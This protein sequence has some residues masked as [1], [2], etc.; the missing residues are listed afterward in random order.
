MRLRF[1]FLLPARLWLGLFMA[2]PLLIVCVYSALTRGAYGGVA[3]PWTAENYTRFFDPLYGVI[4]LRSLLIAAAATALCLL[5]GFPL[6]LFIARARK[7]RALYLF[8]VILPFWTSFLV[9]T[10][11]WLFLLRDSGLI[12]TILLNLGVI[13]EPVQLLYNTGAVLLGLVY[14]YLPFM[15]LPLY[16]TLE[17]LDPALLEAAADL[18]AKPLTALFRVVGPVV[19]A[20]NP[21]RIHPRVHPL[22]GSVPDPRSSGRRQDRHDRQPG[23]ESVHNRARLAVRLRRLPAA[24]ADRGPAR[25]LFL[26]SRR[27]GGSVKRALGLYAVA[28]YAFLHLPLLILGAFSFNSS[29]FTVWEGFSLNWYR[30]VFADPNLAEAAVNSIEIAVVSTLL[31][32]VVGTACAYGFWKRRDRALSGALYLSLVTPEIVTGVSLLAFFQWTFRH[33]HLRLGLHTVIL[34]HVAFSIAYVV[35][36]VAARLRTLDGSLEEGRHGPRR[37]RVAGLPPR[38]APRAACPESWPP[39]CSPSPSPSTTTSSPAWWPASIRKRSQCGS[40]PRRVAAPTPPS[41]RSRS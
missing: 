17:R 14:G 4:L 11:A 7:H 33:L 39:P 16:A 20:G 18:G 22:C 15:I 31:S 37:N 29:R 35:V 1:W 36:V 9:R 23:P 27:R 25:G 24:D 40:T 26:A 28:L 19:R 32:T 6:A 2:A 12:N 5:L 38:D 3:L 41:T 8:L 30:A 13:R 21:R 10:Y 34:A